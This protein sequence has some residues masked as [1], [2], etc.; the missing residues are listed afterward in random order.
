MI[1]V[2]YCIYGFGTGA[3][4]SLTYNLVVATAPPGNAGAAAALNDSGAEFGGAVGIAALGSLSTAIF[5]RGLSDNISAEVPDRAKEIAS[6]NFGNAV[7]TANSLPADVGEDL[8]LQAKSAFV[9]GLTITAAS[10]AVMLT[11][12][13]LVSFVALR[14]VK[15]RDS[16]D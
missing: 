2:G 9:D 3:A 11:I 5:H 15:L 4:V 16:D 1:L 8:K 10:S 6:E 14:R 7:A 13:A 12:M